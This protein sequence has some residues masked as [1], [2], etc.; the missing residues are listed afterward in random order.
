MGVPDHATSH[1]WLHLF[2]IGAVVCVLAAYQTTGTQEAQAAE[3]TAQ[4]PPMQRPE[5]NVGFKWVGLND[6]MVVDTTLVAKTAD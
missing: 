3:V 1:A 4:L 2:A 5:R 6:G